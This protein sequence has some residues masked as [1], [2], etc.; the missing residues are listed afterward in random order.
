M[1]RQ[2]GGTG[3]RIL[4]YYFHI[5]FCRRKCGYCAF[6]SAPSP[7]AELIDAYL[8]H[9]ERQLENASPL[10]RAETIYLGGGTPT[11]LSIRQLERLFTMIEANLAPET[12]C[13]ISIE[14]NPE[15]LDEAKVALLRENVTRISLGAQSFSAE[16]REILGRQCG[17]DALER[18][19]K[20]IG[21]ARFPH[22]NIDLI[23][24]IPGETPD[25]WRK[26]LLR[27]A[28][29]GVDHLSCY[30]LTP[31]EGSRLGASFAVDDDAAQ[32]MYEIIPEM[33]SPYGIRRYEISNYARP[34]A[35]CRHNVNVWRGGLLRGFGPSAAGFDGTD[36]MTEVPSLGDWLAGVPPEIDRIPH[37]RRL[38][39]IF[40]VNL[41]TAAGWTPELWRQ[42]PRADAWK[43][44]LAVIAQSKCKLPA[45]WWKISPERIKLSDE[46]L[47]F[48]NT[49]A[50][51]IL[52]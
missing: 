23:Y 11:L 29:C 10:P 17:D 14:A 19:L 40:A 43:D 9:L 49:I 34:G 35:E 28:D 46:G 1:T 38:A 50:E 3:T 33:L 47:C 37:D 6:Y 12:E 8:D 30:S 26:D 21:D 24:G 39:E 27:A 18:A 15:T 5:P 48:W 51:A 20:L 41:R 44:R 31:E 36:R 32:E 16:R 25:M 22:W 4:N 52:P 13:E 42:V 45:S 2:D 7:A